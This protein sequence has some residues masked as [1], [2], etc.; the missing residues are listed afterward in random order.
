MP[1]G[2]GHACTVC[3]WVMNDVF[4]VCEA[5]GMS[6]AGEASEANGATRWTGAW[7]GDSVFIKLARLR[8][9]AG[10]QLCVIF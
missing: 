10:H 6:E 8:L 5:S 2:G 9:A 7:G 1:I 3:S 4:A